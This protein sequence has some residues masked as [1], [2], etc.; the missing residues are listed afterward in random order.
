MSNFLLTAT[1]SLIFLFIYQP[2]ISAEY[3]VEKGDVM[4]SISE[5]TKQSIECLCYANGI[6]LETLKIK[7][8]QTIIYPNED[9][10]IEAEKFVFEHI[11]GM[12]PDHPD[13]KYFLKIHGYLKIRKLKCADDQEGISLD[14]AVALAE[15]RRALTLN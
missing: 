2:A 1:V 11:L 7:A 6:D 4:G 10:F 12:A 15:A 13:Y 14:E 9:D 8:G 5:K 3:Q